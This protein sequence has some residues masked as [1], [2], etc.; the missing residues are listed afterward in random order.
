MN[1]LK[2][3]MTFTELYH[4]CNFAPVCLCLGI[5]GASFRRNACKTCKT[6][7]DATKLGQLGTRVRAVWAAAGPRT[8]PEQHHGHCRE[9]W[10]LMLIAPFGHHSCGSSGWQGSCWCVLRGG[11]SL[12]PA[13]AHVMWFASTWAC[14]SWAPA[15]CSMYPYQPAPVA[16]LHGVPRMH[17]YLLHKIVP[18]V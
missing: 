15:G 13:W 14:G 5:F 8:Q 12:V 9:V 6:P 17:P 11:A 16:S 18:M 3:M 4:L 1:I 2:T 10:L 7:H